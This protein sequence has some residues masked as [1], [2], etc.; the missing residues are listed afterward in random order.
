MVYWVNH[1]M[2]LQALCQTIVYVYVN[3]Q[4]MEHKY[5]LIDAQPITDNICTKSSYKSTVI[6][7]CNQHI[8]QSMQI[9]NTKLE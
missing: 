8:R 7:K 2:V 1:T 4:E 5:I 3:N 6:D 9:G